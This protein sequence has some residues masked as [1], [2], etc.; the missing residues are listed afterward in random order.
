MET[1]RSS[2]N[3]LG[4]ILE[5]ALNDWLKGHD[6]LKP[7]AYKTDLSP[8]NELRREYGGI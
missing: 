6:A 1:T 4:E 2:K 8:Y 7:Y 3:S 5:N